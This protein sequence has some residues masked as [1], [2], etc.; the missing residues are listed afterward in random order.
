MPLTPQEQAECLRYL[1]YANWS[2]LA[3]S[4]QLGYPAPS[5]PEFMIRDA[6]RRINEEGLELVRRDLCNLRNIEAQ[7][8]D[9]SRLKVTS[10][11]EVKM[12]P[13]EFSD[14]RQRMMY[15]LGKLADD[16]GGYPNPFGHQ[17]LAGTRNA[18]VIG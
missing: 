7:I 10:V 16:L 17:S 1:G 4:F 18:R 15:W 6:F 8:G 5:Q 12:N 2:S 3:S 11:A 9:T 14:L 13:D